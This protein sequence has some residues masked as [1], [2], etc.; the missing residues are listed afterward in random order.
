MLTPERIV[1][2][3]QVLNEK[4]GFKN[5]KLKGGASKGSEEMEAVRA[6]KKAFPNGRINIDPNGARS[7]NEAIEICKPMEGIL[8]Y[9]ENS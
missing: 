8:T 7:L 3:A 1:E 5:F 9:I 6:L 2:Q 4:Y